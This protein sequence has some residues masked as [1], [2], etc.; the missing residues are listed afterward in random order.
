FYGLALVELIEAAVRSGADDASA[1][2]LRELEQRTVPSG[3]DWALGMLARSRALVQRGEAAESLYQEAISR[4]ERTR[5]A[6]DLARAHLLYGEW[7]RREGRRVDARAQ[8]RVAHEMFSGFGAE[9]FADRA[10]AELSAT[11]ETARKRSVESQDVL[12][13]QETQIARLTAEGHTNPEIGSQLFISP[14]T[15]EYHL[16][17]VFTKLGISSRRELRQALPSLARVSTLD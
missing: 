8:L 4:L 15:V 17:K 3:T 16:S 2:A 9:A 5:I 7:L 6:V 1:V 14:R 10:R 13:P 11:G 12:T